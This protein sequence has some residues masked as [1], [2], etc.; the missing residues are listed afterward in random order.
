MF[1]GCGTALVTPFTRDRELDFPAL[2]KLVKRQ[3]DAEIDFLVPMGTTGESPTLEL[4]E[5]LRVIE[6]T[7]EEAKGKVPV[8]AGCGGYYTKH[9]V[10]LAERLEKL[11]ADGLLSVTP[12]YNKPTPEGLYQHYK[13]IAE[14]TK[15]PIVL[16]SVAG[17]TARNIAPSE[18]PRLASIPNVVALKEASGSIQ[19]MG[20]ICQLQIED[21]DVLAG[22]DSVTLPLMALGGVGVISVCANQ[23]PG[24]M[25]ELCAAANA[26]D[27]LQARAIHR[28]WQPLMEVNF[29]ESS[30]GPVKYAMARMGLIEE[31][32]RL[33]MV[34]IAAENKAKVD[35]V[36]AQT[37]LV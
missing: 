14:A 35:K 21:F 31:A 13:A 5:H 27:F 12:Y 3:I 17:R 8:V 1:R 19:Q 25:A 32:Y 18:V 15:L 20:Q 22:D 24:P 9:M 29:C 7:L 16:Y 2:R 4:S 23:I 11:G 34:P 37:G 33:P 6:V 30:P 36:L 26:G 28:Q 10:D